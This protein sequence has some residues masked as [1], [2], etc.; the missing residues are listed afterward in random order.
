[1]LRQILISLGISAIIT[2]VLN[3]IIFLITGSLG[4]QNFLF[5]G[6]FFGLSWPFT[7]KARQ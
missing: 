1:M 2:V 5:I 4:W 7:R 3:A 6:L